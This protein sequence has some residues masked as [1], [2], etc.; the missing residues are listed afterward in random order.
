MSRSNRVPAC[1]ALVLDLVKVPPSHL[2]KHGI[3]GKDGVDR[4]LPFP[5]FLCVCK[6]SQRLV[7][8]SGSASSC[9]LPYKVHQPVAWF[10][11]LW[12][13]S[14]YV[15]CGERTVRFS[16]GV[17]DASVVGREHQCWVARVFVGH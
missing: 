1:F 8:A 6:A 4:S 12:E 16:Q 9:T 5:C 7:T 2:R 15:H 13:H 11:H 14:G 10:M 3:G 17:I